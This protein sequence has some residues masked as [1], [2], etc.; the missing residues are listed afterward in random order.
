MGFAVTSDPSVAPLHRGEAEWGIA[1]TSRAEDA[2]YGDRAAA[3]GV[4]PRAAPGRV[5]PSGSENPWGHAGDLG[6]EAA[7]RL[8]PGEGPALEGT[9]HKQEARRWGHRVGGRR[10]RRRTRGA[11]RPAAK[12]AWEWI[13]LAW[14]LWSALQVGAA[15]VLKGNR[16]EGEVFAFDALRCDNSHA[17]AHYS[18]RQFCD[19]GRI[20]TDNGIPTKVPAGELSVLQLEQ[21]IHFQATVCKKKRSTMKA[22]CGA[23]GHSKLVEPLDIQ[24]PVRLSITECSDVS[25]TQVLTTEDGSQIR[26]PKGSNTMYKYL[27]TGE[28]TLSEGNVACEGGELKIGGK[29]HSNIV[30]LVTIEFQRPPE[31]QRGAPTSSV[32][33]HLRGL[34]VG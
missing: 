18:G 12:T 9:G 19:R 6:E 27:D 31:D 14:C 32:R 25:T 20:K 2:A 7:M 13:L 26:V 29:K 3:P 10:G 22:V 4:L 28:V 5:E 33:T 8:G 34:G 16:V 24:E 23:F 21:E 17:L 15:L 1:G 30:E 11:T